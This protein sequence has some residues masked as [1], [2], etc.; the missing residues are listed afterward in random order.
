M[1]QTVINAMEEFVIRVSMGGE[2][3]SPQE[4]EILPDMIELLNSVEKE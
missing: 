2:N 3:V 1:K 4:T